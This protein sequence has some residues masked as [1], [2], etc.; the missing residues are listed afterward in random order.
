MFLEKF[1]ILYFS[2]FIYFLRIL[3]PLTTNE[4]ELNEGINVIEKGIQYLTQKK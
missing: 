2:N 3:L 1:I 4:N